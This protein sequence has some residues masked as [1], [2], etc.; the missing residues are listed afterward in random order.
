MKPIRSVLLALTVVLVAGC[1]ARANQPHVGEDPTG[2]R[3]RVENESGMNLRVFAVIGSNEL[4]L[5]R[6]ASGQHSSLRLPLGVTGSMRLVART[7]AV[8][9]RSGHVSEPFTLGPGQWMAWRL[10]DSPGASDVRLSSVH[11]FSCDGDPRC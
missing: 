4:L 9:S 2:L 8:R 5:G 7:S 3:I 11:V 1:S 6:V 10:R